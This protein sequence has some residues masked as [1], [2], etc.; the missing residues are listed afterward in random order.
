[1]PSRKSSASL[2]ILPDSLSGSFLFLSEAFSETSCVS[3]ILL[4]TDTLLTSNYHA[5]RSADR[6]VHLST[7]KHFNWWS[8][9]ALTLL[10]TDLTQLAALAD[11]A[12]VT[13]LEEDICLWTSSMTATLPALFSLETRLWHGPTDAQE[14]GTRT[15]QKC[16]DSSISVYIP[17]SFQI[18]ICGF[19]FAGGVW[20][21]CVYLSGWFWR[22]KDREIL[23]AAVVSLFK[24]EVHFAFIKQNSREQNTKCCSS[25][26][27]PLDALTAADI[28]REPFTSYPSQNYLSEQ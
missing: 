27:V 9:I 13:G 11:T 8:K 1:M 2:H 20:C 19:L 26:D 14:E 28:F 25:P 21:G 16:G 10:K 17:P 5:H 22:K 18:S 12:M 7:L 4:L 6:A 3:W 23:H 15:R 24:R